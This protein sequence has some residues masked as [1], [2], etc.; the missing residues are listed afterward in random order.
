MEENIESIV[1][2]NEIVDEEVQG[3]KS[4][5][6]SLADKIL[7][8]KVSFIFQQFSLS[9]EKLILIHPQGP[10]KSLF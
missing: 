3:I 4:D 7:A 5:M 10:V 1:R 6:I 8:L 9:D 2:R